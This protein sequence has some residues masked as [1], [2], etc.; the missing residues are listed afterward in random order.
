M[1]NTRSQVG[2][3]NLSPAGLIEKLALD[4][5][6]DVPKITFDL[7]TLHNTAWD[8]LAKLKA[9]FTKVLGTEFLRYVP[10]EELLPFVVGYV[11]STA[12]GRPDIETKTESKDILINAA[13][14]FV[15]G[16]LA[17]GKGRVVKE[18]RTATVRP[19]EVANIQFNA[20]EPWGLD[21]LMAE[22]QRQAGR[23]GRGGRGGRGGEEECPV[24]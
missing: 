23:V 7:F 21:H 8:L 17:K 24:Q 19:Q 4:V 5:H 9:E 16:F 18:A 11:F 20:T 6:D 22:L 14:R 13:G 1:S 10:R 15:E 3:I 2:F 12:A